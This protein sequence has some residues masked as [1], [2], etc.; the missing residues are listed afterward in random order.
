MAIITVDDLIWFG[1]D[2]DF[3]RVE[4]MLTREF[5]VDGFT[6][7]KG[8]DLK[9]LGL[10]VHQDDDGVHWGQAAYVRKVLDSVDGKLRVA[11]TT[12]TPSYAMASENGGGNDVEDPILDQPLSQEQ[13]VEFR[14]IVACLSWLANQTRPDICVQVRL[15]AS[16]QNK[17]CVRDW[18]E[19]LHLLGYLSTH[20]EEQRV[21]RVPDEN[22]CFVV[23][24][25]PRVDVISDAAFATHEGYARSGWLVLV[26]GNVVMYGTDK[27]TRATMSASAAEAIAGTEAAK[28]G[29]LVK[30]ML[31]AMGFEVPPIRL[32]TDSEIVVKQMIAGLRQHEVFKNTPSA[33]RVAS[34]EAAWLRE[35]YVQKEMIPVHIPG[36]V[37]VADL[38][39]KRVEKIVMQERRV[40]L[41][42]FKAYA[43]GS[44]A[45]RHALTLGG[46]VG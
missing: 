19:M 40:G 15:L 32:F 20:C 39:T 2:G 14:R 13:H 36:K 11:N 7:Q 12:G 22:D 5:G 29:M 30:N 24:G 17:P 3:A 46:C 27:Q 21:F 6:T 9:L 33:A 1:N 25:V 45:W 35:R 34:A 10:D 23:N 28:Y 43:S 44:L 41:L 4:E 37:N 38:L 42:D 16:H 26:G 31:E 8:S 18:K